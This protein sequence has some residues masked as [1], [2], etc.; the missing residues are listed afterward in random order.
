MPEQPIILSVITQ[1]LASTND[2][3]LMSLLKTV[4]GVT[5]SIILRHEANLYPSE[6][7]NDMPVIELNNVAIQC[8]HNWLFHERENKTICC[9][10][11]LDKYLENRVAGGTNNYM[12]EGIHG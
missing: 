4:Q 11:G 9:K 7:V 6:I 1:V 8:D 3:D 10:C 2:D 12:P 5:Q